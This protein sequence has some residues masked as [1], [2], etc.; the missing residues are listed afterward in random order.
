M[1]TNVQHKMLSSVV[2]LPKLR[3]RRRKALQIATRIATAMQ[4][5][6]PEIPGAYSAWPLQKKIYNTLNATH[7]SI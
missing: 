7:R 6:T 2:E 1:H 4:Q 3:E 5:V